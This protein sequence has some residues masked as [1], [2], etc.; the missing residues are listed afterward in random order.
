MGTFLFPHTFIITFWPRPPRFLI[1]RSQ[2][3]RKGPKG[4]K[5]FRRRYFVLT[6]KSLTYAKSRGDSPLC[7]IPLSHMLAVERVDDQAFNMK[8]VSLCL[9]TVEHAGSAVLFRICIPPLSVCHSLSS[10]HYTQYEITDTPLEPSPIEQYC[11]TYCILFISPQQVVVRPHYAAPC[12]NPGSMQASTRPRGN[13]TTI[14]CAF[15]F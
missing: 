12:H 1:K 10:Y 4:P 8:F 11:P 9:K 14:Q 15:H 13:S 6:G 2:G 3:R 7:E 5:N